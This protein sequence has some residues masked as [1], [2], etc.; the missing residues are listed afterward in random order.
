M[1]ERVIESFR[2]LFDAVIA[3]APEFL[4]GIVLLLVGVVVAK[5][6]EKILRMILVRLKFDSLVEKT[7]IDQTIQKIGIRK[8][9][10]HF[11]PRLV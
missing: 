8:E 2:E 6:I 10:N 11:L 3:A 1:K 9:L 5:V 4:T 7:G